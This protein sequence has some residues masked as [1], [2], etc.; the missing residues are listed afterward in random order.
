M[1]RTNVLMAL[2]TNQFGIGILSIPVTLKTLGL[3]PGLVVIIGMEP[4]AWYGGYLLYGIV[5]GTYWGA[6]VAFFFVVL[7]ISACASIAVTMSISLNII[8]RHGTCIVG[9]IGIAAILTVIISLG[10]NGPD[11]APQGWTRQIEL[12]R[13]PRSFREIFTACLRIVFAYAG[14]FSF[15]S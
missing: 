1:N 7:I 4:V 12:V 15:V 11:S 5:G 13:S 8:T 3:I 9:F 10:V 6:V 2:L 14:Q